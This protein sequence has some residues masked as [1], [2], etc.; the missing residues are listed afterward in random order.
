MSYLLSAR[1]LPS[2][3]AIIVLPRVAVTLRLQLGGR[4]EGGTGSQSSV[5]QGGT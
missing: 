3:K 4:G 1:A 2:R 5:G